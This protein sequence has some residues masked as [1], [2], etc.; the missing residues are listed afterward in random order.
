MSDDRFERLCD[1][2]EQL[3]ARIEGLLPAELPRA[4]TGDAGAWRWQ[5][6]GPGYGGFLPVKAPA[7]LALTE[8]H[9]IDE[10][11]AALDRNTRQFVAGLPCNNALL[12]GARGTG[13]SSLVKA[14]F[15]EY[16]DRGLR[17]VEVDATDL[18]DLPDVVAPLAGR[19]ERF[20]L[21]ADD[22]AFDA[23]NPGYRSLKALL[24]GSI[25]SAPDNVVVYATSNRRHL[26]PEFMAENR[27][28]RAV[29]DE[30]HPGE[31]T[32]EKISLSERFGLW[33][34]FHPFR[35]ADYLA[36]AENWLMRIDPSCP[37]DEA[38][39]AQALQWAL[40]R[41]SR[42]GRVA[43]QFA[44]DWAGRARLDDGGT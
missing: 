29:D 13:K 21:F 37:F 4:P 24:E 33:L 26:M 31:T 35:Q 3:L 6:R 5:R 25:A 9:G 11:K 42:S 1:R 43:H 23:D 16:R 7:A 34:S 19:E 14:L 8:L 10:Q 2:A 41:G 38:A 39:R 36:I 27:E 17:L 15:A 22:L 32:E 28:A 18:L 44:L 12:W 20:V 30:I 40:L